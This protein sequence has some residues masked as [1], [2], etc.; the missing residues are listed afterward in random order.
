MLLMANEPFDLQGPP[1][2]DPQAPTLEPVEAGL[3]RLEGVRYD[4]EMIEHNSR[5]RRV[6][7]VA[8]GGGTFVQTGT[9]VRFV[10]ILGSQFEKR[11][12]RV[13]GDR[14]V[15]PSSE[16]VRIRTVP[17][18]PQ[19]YS[20]QPQT[21]P[22]KRII[23][24]PRVDTIDLTS[25]QQD[26]DLVHEDEYRM[27]A[28]FAKRPVETATTHVPSNIS[29]Q[30]SIRTA[31]VRYIRPTGVPVNTVRRAPATIRPLN[32]VPRPIPTGASGNAFGARVMRQ[33]I[34]RGGLVQRTVRRPPVNMARVSYAK[35]SD[36]LKRAPLVRRPAMRFEFERN[37]DEERA[38]AE[39]IA[40][41]EEIMRQEEEAN[42]KTKNSNS[43]SL[44][45]PFDSDIRRVEEGLRQKEL[46]TRS[47]LERR[48]LAP[49][50]PLLST[51]T[52]PFARDAATRHQQMIEQTQTFSKKPSN[53]AP[54]KDDSPD[55]RVAKQLLDCMI[56]QV[57]KNEKPEKPV[58]GWQR[59][60][61]QP[62][63]IRESNNNRYPLLR[64]NQQDMQLHER[65]DILKREVMKRRQKIEEIA[66]RE[67][68]ITPPWKKS[69]ARTKPR[70]KKKP[71]DQTQIQQNRK[72]NVTAAEVEI[73]MVEDPSQ[74][75]LGGDS[76]VYSKIDPS[77]ESAPPDLNDL[78][79]EVHALAFDTDL[80]ELT[81]E[82]LSILDMTGLLET[83]EIL[84]EGKMNEPPTELCIPLPSPKK[85]I[86]TS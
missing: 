61:P 59:P 47:E 30:P 71:V 33:M 14:H 84:E 48:R 23:A 5:V 43:L 45:L 34:G 16:F 44:F 13:A 75:S 55:M 66:E 52:S 37:E 40:V 27:V 9:G 69:R 17:T 46:A 25:E 8:R 32:A 26:N 62:I 11:P 35:L 54:S 56:S 24:E 20:I 81:P 72:E 3:K 7:R 58:V 83:E 53:L 31:P 79:D 64:Y 77:E 28:G 49:S 39:A 38:I 1:Q 57:C 18:A 4:G 22:R 21:F 15:A 74:I 41:E 76:V 80:Q 12:I 70:P 78:L 60:L 50:N 29:Q 82:H 65:M 86:L 36:P 2:L 85:S 51:Y 6:T 73:K 63:R 42:D 10:R 19:P 67:T 68:G